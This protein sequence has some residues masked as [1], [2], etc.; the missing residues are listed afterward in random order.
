M[1]FAP[2]A[3][4]AIS[5]ALTACDADDAKA[6]RLAELANGSIDWAL[7]ALR[8]PQLAEEREAEL[9]RAWE[10]VG[11][12]EFDRMVLAVRIADQFV[13]DREGTYAFLGKV[14][15]AWRSLLYQKAGVGTAM[16]PRLAPGD[17]IQL[18]D[19]VRSVNAVSTCI[20][21]LSANVRPRL[22][23][24]SMVLQWVRLA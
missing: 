4:G 8:T 12:S 19:I 3:S 22:A 13:A 18:A 6:R 17:N 5:R 9:Q 23:L 2:V 20:E 7:A 15:A 16:Q 21:N 10:L 1:R 14:Q 11:A 24:E